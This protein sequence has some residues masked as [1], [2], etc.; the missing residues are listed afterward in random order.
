MHRLST[1]KW[2]C[3]DSA[4]DTPGASLFRSQALSVLNGQALPSEKSAGGH[5]PFESPLTIAYY[6]V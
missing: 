1:Q 3:E 5:S 2:A 4:P 6:K